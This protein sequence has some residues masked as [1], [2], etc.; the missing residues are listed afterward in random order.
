MSVW[1]WGDGGP[2]AGNPSLRLLARSGQSALLIDFTIP[3][4]LLTDPC[5]FD[6]LQFVLPS[7]A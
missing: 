1:Y 2:G 4:Y 5:Q 7:L 6:I 3:P